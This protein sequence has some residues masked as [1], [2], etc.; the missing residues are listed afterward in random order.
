MGGVTTI[1]P[2][3]L[4]Y[5]QQ[6]S[7]PVLSIHQ[8][9]CSLIVECAV[10]YRSNIATI[11]QIFI[12]AREQVDRETNTDRQADRQTKR[13]MDRRTDRQT[14]LKRFTGIKAGGTTSCPA[15]S[16]FRPSPL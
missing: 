14:Y 7:P 10:L 9:T 3:H 1:V 4:H 11:I 8:R 13:D 2:A 12:Q 16:Y 6:H 5:D 15:Q